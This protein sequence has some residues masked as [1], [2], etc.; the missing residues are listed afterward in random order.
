MSRQYTE[1][2]VLNRVLDHIW[3]LIGYWNSEGYSNVEKTRS[4]RE[5]MEGLAFSILAMLDG[6]CM[7]IPKFIV[8]PDPHPADKEYH[9]DN[10]ENWFPDN[11]EANIE[12]DLG[13][14]LHE[15]FN[16]RRPKSVH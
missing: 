12:C 1:E 6:S 11:S 16:S 2:E 4:T 7:D 13:G 9:Q 10:D 14:G 3:H 5:R 15:L 8:A